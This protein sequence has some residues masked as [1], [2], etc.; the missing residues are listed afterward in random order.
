MKKPTR[1]PKP[2]PKPR[3]AKDLA[4]LLAQRPDLVAAAMDTPVALDG[5]SPD[6]RDARRRYGVDLAAQLYPGNLAAQLAVE[7]IIG[8]LRL[9]P[10][11]PKLPEAVALLAG[12]KDDARRQASWLARVLRLW[13]RADVDF[14]LARYFTPERRAALASRDSDR[15]TAAERRARAVLLDAVIDRDKLRRALL[16]LAQHA[17]ATDGYER[18]ARN[19]ARVLSFAAKRSRDEGLRLFCRRHFAQLCGLSAGQRFDNA[20]KEFPDL[21]RD[22]EVASSSSADASAFHRAWKK[23]AAALAGPGHHHGDDRGRRPS[24]LPP[25]LASRCR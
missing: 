16:A 2:A 24:R 5:D 13:P 22:G 17:D 7:T 14:D 8:E 1:R 20:R 21:L 9:K 10:G 25:R 18:L 19:L 11:N 15:L 4:A 12:K 3:P 23:V 6:A